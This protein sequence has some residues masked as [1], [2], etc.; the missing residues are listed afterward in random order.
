[1]DSLDQPLSTHIASYDISV[2]L[3]T[4]R[5]M[6]YADQTVYW[7]NPGTQSIS[8][9]PFHLYL[10]AFKNS[11]S[12]FYKESGLTNRGIE[13]DQLTSRDWGWI[14]IDQ[15][16]LANGQDVTERLKYIQPNDTNRADQ[17]VIQ[18]DLPG[19][20]APGET[21]ELKLKFTA[22][23]PKI[24]I[25]T[26]YSKNYYLMVQWFPKV[27][28]YEPPG[29]RFSVDG[30]WNCHQYHASTEYYADFGAYNVDITVPNGY[31]VG[32]SGKLQ[33]KELNDSTTTHF[34][35]AQDI[36]DFGWTASPDFDIVRDRWKNVDLNLYIIPEYR[37]CT[38]RYLQAAKNTLE[39]MGNHFM[40]YPFS[41]LTIVVPPFH[42]LRSGAMEYPT[43]VTAPGM[44]RFPT[45][46]RSPEYFVVHETIHQYFMMMVA[47]NEFEEAWMD[48]G[49]TSYYE[50]RILDH[51][52][53]KNKSVID[54]G[55]V[56]M[57][58]MEFRRTRYVAM[59]NMHVAEMTRPGWEFPH[60][61]YRE[62]VYSKA[63]TMLKTLEGIVG[64][65]VMDRIMK[66]YFDRWK[67]K[68]PCRFDFI[69][70]VNEVVGQLNDPML[71]EDMNWFFDQVLY[72]TGICDYAVASINN[73]RVSD[74]KIGIF[75][76][77]SRV[78]ERVDVT[79]TYDYESSVI[80]HRL[81]EVKLPVEVLIHFSDGNSI[82]EQWDGQDR[83]FDFTYR[84]NR[85]IEWVQLDPDQ[86]LYMDVNFLNNGKKAEKD[87]DRL[88]KKYTY[89]LILRLQG[90][91]QFLSFLV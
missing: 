60:G 80:L 21:L 38:D 42:G 29:M 77:G 28:V 72:G 63:A 70:V 65:E 71:G 31:Q 13:V 24:K 20:V 41:D 68:H 64:L 36:I 32:A 54:L 86:R 45:S 49:F 35:R 82:M 18:L 12:T 37:C 62:L 66:T 5:K 33:R 91:F 30:Q 53:G 83:A 50:S 4:S 40:D 76:P 79:P 43:F 10:N 85:T 88:V 46:L 55:P 47:T 8:E 61:G 17:T 52:Y 59:D 44:Y 89:D 73:K 75:E 27:G 84:G 34:Y 90:L 57:G 7:T 39:Y 26:G 19:S 56:G 51:Y 15:I 87:N 22:K 9:I 16:Q 25:R 48:E 3:D 2:R 78:A 11:E 14:N 67:F 23:I 1:M 69:E 81:G 74:F 58:A 6:I